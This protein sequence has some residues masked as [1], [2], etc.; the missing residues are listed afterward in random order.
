[1]N[2][3]QMEFMTDND[4]ERLWTLL[5]IDNTGQVDPIDF[6]SFLKDCAP[7]FQEVH[8]EY[9]TLP[10]SERLKLA[11]RRLSN[12]S[13]MGEEE[14]L[15]MERRNNKRSR[16]VVLDESAMTKLSSCS[17]FNSPAAKATSESRLFG[18]SKILSLKTLRDK[19]FRSRSQQALPQTP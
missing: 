3:L 6:I 16:E 17:E 2:D 11:S 1:M 12:I 5:D 9:S 8:K 13:K 10:K 7:Q 15:K 18:I 4:F 14:V 19:S